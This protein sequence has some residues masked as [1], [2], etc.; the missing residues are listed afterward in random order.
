MAELDRESIRTAQKCRVTFA[1]KITKVYRYRVSGQN[2]SIRP[3]IYNLGAAWEM[4]LTP[5]CFT[6]FLGNIARNA[7]REI[8]RNRLCF[9]F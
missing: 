6:E 4:I 8:E 9:E 7:A 2:Y 3:F 5:T 1:S